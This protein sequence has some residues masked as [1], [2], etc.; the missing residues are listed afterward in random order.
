MKRLITDNNLANRK[1]MAVFYFVIRAVVVAY[2]LYS[3][4]EQEYENAI[5][6]AITLLLLFVPS[7]IEKKMKIELPSFLE[8][9][10]T[11]FVFSSIIL[12][13]VAD[14]YE[15]FPYFDTVLHTING[16][17]CAAVGFGLIDIMN[18]N[19]KFKLSLSPI[20]VCLFSFCFSMTAGVIWEFFEYGIDMFLGKDMQRDTIIHSINS[21]LLSRDSAGENVTVIKNI[22]QTSI[23]GNKLWIDGYLDIGLIDTMNDL[24]VNFIGAVVFNTFGFIYLKNRGKKISFINNLVPK[25]IYK[26]KSH[27]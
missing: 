1:W 5:T 9:L 20:F 15:K 3:L 17:I 22:S 10:V 7:F 25:R 2:M 21:I 19:S 4:A 16:F 13:G 12:G 11:I 18:N 14:Y 23:N 27:Y 8:L 26:I 6:S 24:L